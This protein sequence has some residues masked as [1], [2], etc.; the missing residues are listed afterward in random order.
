MTLK[1]DGV[2]LDLV[3]PPTKVN[4]LIFGRT[5]VDSPGEMIM[6]N[7]TTGDKAVL[8]F[9]PCGWLGYLANHFSVCHLK[10][11]KYLLVFII[12]WHFKQFLVM[13]YYV[14]LCEMVV[15]HLRNA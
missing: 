9:Q 5:W 1:K 3:P 7:L 15:S 4:N 8:Y 11:M 2:V 10:S 6:T 12:K 13:V 14:K